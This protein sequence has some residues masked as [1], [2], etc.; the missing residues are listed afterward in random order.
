MKRIEFPGNENGSIMVVTLVILTLAT[1][2]GV[3]ATTTT[4]IELQVSGNDLRY[5]ENFYRAEAAAMVGARVIEDSTKLIDS[6]PQY[7]NVDEDI[8]LPSIDRDGQSATI[9]HP[10]NI[11]DDTNWATGT[12]E[13]SAEAP[14]SE[15]GYNTR[16]LPVLRVGAPGG[17]ASALPG[18]QMREFAIYG[19]SIRVNNNNEK[20]GEVIIEVGYKKRF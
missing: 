6:N 16:F 14:F 1:M 13:I 7:T 2:I 20:L 9:P 10:D 11:C 5:A 8:P 17:D 4:S 15:A 3:A 18:S 19:R 12:G